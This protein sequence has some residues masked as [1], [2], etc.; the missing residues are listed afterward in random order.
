MKKLVA[1]L[2]LLTL[3]LSMIMIAVPIIPINASPGPA[4]TRE[5]SARA[6]RRMLV[7]SE[8]YR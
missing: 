4:E 7:K 3:V 1:I 6:K 5:V 8:C 2:M